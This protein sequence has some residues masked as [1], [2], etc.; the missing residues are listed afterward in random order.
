MTFEIEMAEFFQSKE[1]VSEKL[2]TMSMLSSEFADNILCDYAI[3][4][5]TLMR[6]KLQFSTKIINQDHETTV[7]IA[8]GRDQFCNQQ[9]SSDFRKLQEKFFQQ[10]LKSSSIPPFP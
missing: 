9:I 1:Q 5:A 7:V 2:I 4:S 10:N 8:W 3:L 6:L